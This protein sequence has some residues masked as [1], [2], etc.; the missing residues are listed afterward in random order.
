MFGNGKINYIVSLFKN[1]VLMLFAR[2]DHPKGCGFADGTA[3]G[4]SV[5]AVSCPTNYDKMQQIIDKMNAGFYGTVSKAQMDNN[6][7]YNG[8]RK[9]FGNLRD[10]HGGKF[11]LIAVYA[12]VGKYLGRDFYDTYLYQV[13]SIGDN[14]VFSRFTY[15]EVIN[16]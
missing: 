4:Y 11:D 12:G 6:E 9:E 16:N 2:N 1:E 14:R 5:V 13:D 8:D 10:W 7:F 3:H 15:E